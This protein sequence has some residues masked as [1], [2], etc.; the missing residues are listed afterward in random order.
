MKKILIFGL[1]IVSF[2]ILS[3]QKNSKLQ[4]EFASKNFEN[5]KKIE[6]FLKN[7]AGKF[8]S[9]EENTMKSTLACF[10]GGM[11]IFLQT[12]DKPG[13]RS[14]NLTNLQ[15]GTLAGLGG[16]L[17]DGTGINILI[18]DGGTIQ[19]THNEFGGPT[20]NPKRV[21]NKEDIAT[22]AKSSHAT[23][24]TGII[25]GAGVNSAFTWSDNTTTEVGA[26]QGVLKKATSDNYAFATTALGTNY[27]KLE[28]YGVN[29]SNHSYGVNLG[30][31]YRT[32]P[33]T[34]WYWV[35]N[36]NFN[37]EDTWSGSY[38]DNDANFDKIV[39]TNPNQIVV[40][41]AGNYYGSGPDGILPNFKYNS[42]TGTYVP[43]A[44]TDELP[45][46]NCSLGYN[47]IGWGSLAKN[48]IV[49]GATYQL[50]TVNNIY[51]TSD[52]VIKADFSSAGPRKDGA[53]KP[54]VCAVGVDIVAPSSTSNTSY[55]KGAGTSYSAPIVSGVAGAVTQVS[56]I[57]NSNP[58][59]TY[60]ADEMK[61]LLTHTANEAGNPG[62]DVWYGWGFVDAQKASQ[63]VIN[64][65]NN[66]VIFESN[67]LTSGV[68]Y[69]REIKAKASE[70]LKATISWVDPAAVPFTTD[71]DLQN[72]HASRLINDLDLRIIDTT[73]N[74]IYYP[75]RLD[76]TNPMANATKADNTVDNVEQ[77]LIDAPI[78]GRT[79]RIEVGNKGNL[80]NDSGVA[81]P[82]NYALI[83]TG[84]DASSLSTEE[85]SAEKLITIYPT[86]TKDIVTILIP[87]KA[88]SIELFDMSGK[89]IMKFDAKV[90]QTVDLSKLIR[91]IYIFNIKTQ[92]GTVSK[93]VIKE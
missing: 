5:Q 71:A 59:F 46:A 10:A 19:D 53:I 11:P 22:V 91:G 18:M 31:A 87:N 67:I 92:N 44:T 57:I 50:T 35:G 47:C 7:N 73:D 90:A 27:Q 68:K 20:A 58:T 13:N 8:S 33:T 60:K 84:V 23:N 32:S 29:I 62:P 24:V 79:Y 63:V 41:S 61:A 39:Y 54:D 9:E 85:I 77:V 45:P 72:N 17:I 81:S 70:P 51:A 66:Q 1:G 56:R 86:R 74:T 30:W 16:T 89:Q 93:K 6:K 78:A 14:A 65:K 43:F 15:N 76:I 83:V 38:G 3:A 88:K 75:W 28:A 12:D 49:V 82:Q 36:Y 48:I 25:L 64:K 40:K 26:A 4:A 80:V 34:G 55:I 37:H 42:V 69:F 2:G 21:T 52:D